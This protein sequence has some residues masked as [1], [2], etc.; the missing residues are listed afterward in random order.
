MAAKEDWHHADALRQPQGGTSQPASTIGDV[1]A[2]LQQRIDAL[3]HDQVH[4]RIFVK[5]YQ[6]TT[7]AVG[8][9]VDS[10]FFEDPEWGRALGYRLRWAVHRGA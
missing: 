9:A 2:S 10:V 6:R 1:V 3:P 8:E 4:R 5:T 7:Q